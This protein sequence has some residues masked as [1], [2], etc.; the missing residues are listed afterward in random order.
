MGEKIKTLNYIKLKWPFLFSSDSNIVKYL[1]WLISDSKN[2][3]KPAGD[4]A[5]TKKMVPLR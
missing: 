5:E 4:F 3:I 1:G 2:E